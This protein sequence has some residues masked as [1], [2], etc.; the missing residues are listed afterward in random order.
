MA[1]PARLFLDSAR[2]GPMSPSAQLAAR[3]FAR[4]AGE[5][6]STLYFEQFLRR[7]WPSSDETLRRRLPGLAAWSG[8]EE[9]HQSVRRLLQL[10]PSAPVLF[11]SRT[12]ELMRLAARLLCERCRN[13]LVTD[14]LWPAYRSL[15][16][17]ECRRQDVRVTTVAL[18]RRLAAGSWS[19]GELLALLSG[20]YHYH[21]CDGLFLAGVSHDGVR[22]PALSLTALLRHTGTLK[23]AVIDA[24]QKLA[25]VPA[26]LSAGVC[27]FYFAGCHKWLGGYQ[28]LGLAV[29]SNPVTAEGLLRAA[30]DDV[31]G[32]PLLQF[33]DQPEHRWT[34]GWETLNF[35]P[36]FTAWG[37][38]RDFHTRPMTPQQRF[39][40]RCA[41]ARR[42]GRLAELSGWRAV[43]SGYPARS[44]ILLL[45]S[46]LPGEITPTA[47]Q[48]Q[49]HF[50]AQG[51]TLTVYS[52]GLIRVALP[53]RTLSGGQLALLRQ[54]LDLRWMVPVAD[55]GMHFDAPLGSVR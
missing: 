5:G 45:R 26:D 7:G 1:E 18:R 35:S 2:Q 4:L 14:T 50:D 39:R 49:R 36:L 3:D 29:F 25:H 19:A 15:L 34:A 17:E 54:A 40:V 30:V 44:G 13:I 51:V 37:A 21:A 8:L 27:D 33:L 52:Q 12:T 28:P 31:R 42:V 53:D 9:M 43:W 47:E 24:A 48:L 46:E 6:R 32:D 41:N 10:P 16:D 55:Y 22:L 11:A 20:N 23:L 38:L